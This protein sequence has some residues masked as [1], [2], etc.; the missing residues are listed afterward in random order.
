MMTVLLGALP[1]LGGP[2][3]DL[4]RRSK[5]YKLDI[6]ATLFYAVRDTQHGRRRVVQWWSA[7]SSTCHLHHMYVHGIRL[8]I[9]FH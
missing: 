3:V 1:M 5:F 6:W 7:R 8:E 4:R 9:I 2:T